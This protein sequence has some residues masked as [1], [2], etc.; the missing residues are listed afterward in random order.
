LFKASF[1]KIFF[2]FHM[3]INKNLQPIQNYL[4]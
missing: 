4:L 3:M 2:I 1:S